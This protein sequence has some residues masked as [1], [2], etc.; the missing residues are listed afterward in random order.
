[1]AF[2]DA[3]QPRVHGGTDLDIP[4]RPSD[5]PD[6]PLQRPVGEIARAGPGF[7]AEAERGP[8]RR[9]CLGFG[10]FPG[11][12]HRSQH[13]E[14]ALFRRVRV[15]HRRIARRR[16]QKSRQHRGL[17][18][19]EIPDRSAEIAP[20]GGRDAIGAGTEIDPVDVDLED[21][22][23]GEPGFE[24]ER[25]DRLLDLPPDRPLRREEQ[26]LGE[27]LGQRAAALADLPGADIGDRRAEDAPD[28]DPRMVEE[29]P[30]LDRADG[31]DEKARELVEPDRAAIEL[32]VAREHRP[33]GGPEQHRRPA[34]R[35][36][37]PGQVGQV[38]GVPGDRA[39]GGDADPDTE[40]QGPSGEPRDPPAPRG[41]TSAG[42]RSPAGFAVRLPLS[43][44]FSVLPPCHA[45]RVPKCRPAR[46]T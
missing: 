28:V 12:D 30:V 9:P 1:M 2:G 44:P 41:P 43:V 11:I 5:I 13:A 29:A 46:E 14:P 35:R 19:R 6:R 27:L 18:Q 21:L 16:L 32:A 39:A 3:L 42:L 25:D 37:Q 23:L 4:R 20:G 31:L 26:V 36:L 34:G 22:A 10:E 45:Q 38:P 8:Q 40:H 17:E 33:V 7:R 15:P 24:P